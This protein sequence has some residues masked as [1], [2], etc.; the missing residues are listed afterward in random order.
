MAPKNGDDSLHANPRK[1]T[2]VSE[3]NV[4]K[5]AKKQNRIRERVREIEDNSKGLTVKGNTT[6]LQQEVGVALCDTVPVQ[7]AANVR[8]AWQSP[9]A[10]PKLLPSYGPRND[11][12]R[13]NELGCVSH[14]VLFL[15]STNSQKYCTN[16]NSERYNRNRCR[17]HVYVECSVN[18]VVDVLR[19]WISF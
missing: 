3:K 16:G 15:P 18:P 13:A 11:E 1:S 10:P 5:N 19:R 7:R 14:S 2:Q 9:P 12:V 6:V 17:K 8:E 4:A